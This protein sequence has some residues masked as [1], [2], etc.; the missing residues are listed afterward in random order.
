M[1]CSGCIFY[2]GHQYIETSE[3]PVRCSL[4]GTMGAGN[5]CHMFR[6]RREA[7]QT[8]L[9]NPA[10]SKRSDEKEKKPKEKSQ[11][12]KL[13]EFFAK[14]RGIDLS[15]PA[16]IARFFSVHGSAAK[17]ILDM[18]GGNLEEAEKAIEEISSYLDKLVV[19]KKID[20]WQNLQAVANSFIEWKT[21]KIKAPAQAA[22]NPV[23]GYCGKPTDKKFCPECSWCGPC[24]DAGRDPIKDPSELVIN[25]SGPGLVCKSCLA[26]G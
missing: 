21:R 7:I 1:L 10:K 5:G 6:E 9:S 8:L 26:G 4:T 25:P 12:Q 2:A 3:S 13:V 18:A 23:C 11:Y 22:K 24:D 14:S 16:I 17:D 15:N 19:D 20:K